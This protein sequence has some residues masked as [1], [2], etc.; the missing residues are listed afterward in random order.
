MSFVRDVSFLRDGSNNPML[1][2]NNMTLNNGLIG[3]KTGFNAVRGIIGGSARKSLKSKLKNISKK[4]R[5]RYSKSRINR[6]KQTLRQKYA[7]K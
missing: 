3:S 5:K 4:H 2:S 7:K 6:Y 1:F